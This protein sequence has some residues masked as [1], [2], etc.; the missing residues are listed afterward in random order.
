[1][2]AEGTRPGS[3]PS[4][5]HERL[6]RTNHFP[7]FGESLVTQPK[8][9]FRD[10]ESLSPGVTRTEWVTT[11]NPSRVEWRDPE[12]KEGTGTVSVVVAD[13]QYASQIKV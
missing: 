12:Y 10:L 4:G 2:L 11:D 9:P 8:Y 3:K 6:H 7:H 13:T 1:M 5:V